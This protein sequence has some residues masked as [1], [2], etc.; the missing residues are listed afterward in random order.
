MS[1]NVVP[2]TNIYLK[3]AP[4]TS[5]NSLFQV[6]G[7]P[8]G[9]NL[10]GLAQ[11]AYSTGATPPP[12]SASTAPTVASGL[13]M[14]FFAGKSA[15]IASPTVSV[16]TITTSNFTPV[17]TGG[18]TN[19]IYIALG[20]AAG[21]TQTAN[22]GTWSSGPVLGTITQGNNYY[23]S[24]YLSNATL[25]TTS[26]SVSNTN[27][28]GIPNKPSSP[29]ISLT[30]LSSWALSW[31]APSTGIAPTSYSWVLCNTS[32]G[33]QLTSGSTASTSVS[34]T[35]TLTQAC[36]Y[37]VYVT[38]VRPEWSGAAS[39]SNSGNAVLNPPTAVSGVDVTAI[40]TTAYTPTV[41]G[42]TGGTIYIYFGTSSSG[43]P[44]TAYTNAS[45][46]A[47]ITQGTT[48]YLNARSSNTTTYTV[49][50]TVSTVVGIPNAPAS[51][52]LTLSN[53]GKFKID[54]GT[55]TGVQPSSYNW[56]LSTTNSKAQQVT[57]G[58]GY[59]GTG[60]GDI[61]SYTLTQD[62]AYY[63]IVYTNKSGAPEAA[64]VASSSS[65]LAS[66]AAVSG[67][68]VTAISTTAYTPTVSGGTGGTIYIYFGTSS[69][70]TP[71]TAYTNA[72]T[73]ASITQ[74]T[75]YYLNAR[76]SNTTTQ[77]ISPTVT[78]VVGIPN[79]PASATL[80]LTTLSNWSIS[81]GTVTG[82]APASYTWY[83]STTNSKTNKVYSNTV[84]STTGT[85]TL[86]SALT[87]DQPYYAIV[88]TNKSGASEA[89]SVT[90]SSNLLASPTAPTTYSLSNL[91]TSNATVKIAGNTETCYLAI[92]TT[93]GASNVPIGL[94]SG[95]TCNAAYLQVSDATVVYGAFTVG[96]NYYVSYFSS[97]TTTGTVSGTVTSS[98][99]VIP[100]A[101]T[102]TTNSN[103]ISNTT[104]NVAATSSTSGATITYS[105]S[106]TSGVSGTGP[107]T[108]LTSD[109]SYT[110][111]ATASTG[112]SSTSATLDA[113]YCLKKPTWVG[114]SPTLSNVTLSWSNISSNAT[115]VFITGQDGSTSYVG[116]DAPA[117]GSNTFT[118]GSYT[119]STTYTSNTLVRYI[120]TAEG[121]RTSYASDR[122]SFIVVKPGIKRTIATP[123]NSLNYI[124]IGGSGGLGCDTS[125]NLGSGGGEAGALF[126]TTTTLPTNSTL[127][128]SC[129]QNGD[130]GNTS[131]GSG[132][133]SNVLSGDGFMGCRGGAGR[134]SGGSAYGGAG[135]CAGGGGSGSQIACWDVSL[136]IIAG[137]G[138]GMGGSGGYQ[139]GKGG[140]GGSSIRAGTSNKHA[141]GDPG[142]SF[143][144]N[145]Y[146]GG[147]GG[148]YYGGRGAAEGIGGAS[149]GIYNS[150]ATS[151]GTSGTNMSIADSNAN[152]GA[153]GDGANYYGTSTGGGG[154]GYGGGGAGVARNNN[155]S[156]N[157]SG[158]GGGATFI[159]DG[160]ATAVG[161]ASSPNPLVGIYCQNY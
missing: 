4:G 149:G 26:L 10:A 67:V 56:Y 2:A 63:A 91:T 46:A 8:G 81:W 20:T 140:K 111:T 1:S 77:T 116:T 21:G 9:N 49:T 73:A 145:L 136:R 47:S 114:W 18:G 82:V 132:Y 12:F 153:G 79:A 113:T 24:T 94:T 52:T 19:T 36:N 31:T 142:E 64:S 97:N 32:A 23:I 6:F 40:S 71:A 89:A 119:T 55:V 151:A 44:A 117:T 72:S 54:W 41:S 65:T 11:I 39:Q 50:A 58:T 135:G 70:G 104:F 7:T 121:T 53:L 61:T 59:T 75:T 28:F 29:S 137:G 112:Y 158:G 60:T 160:S 161:Y 124:C 122:A 128:L 148:G 96:S 100:V 68:D 13:S 126:G 139:G 123:T 34:G 106:P 17:V 129:G 134:G 138:G 16:S 93:S 5:N 42:G 88:Y 86:T 150:T 80:T 110:V 62:Q 125:N 30:N 33:T 84:T 108:G 103:Y 76:S 131:I 48:Y 144:N 87:Q 109:T 120:V 141:W 15:Y 107:F 3:T 152:V 95:G 43:T 35:T 74:G 105:I 90:S 102:F 101:P 78:T 130:N 25:T 37:A 85:G 51:A 83:L 92:G 159:S 147:N 38:A 157:S 127:T 133:T 45:T 154:G 14:S 118:S 27:A 66:P 69:S 156:Y 99:L 143:L 155:G 57:S 22:W 115:R 146:D 98:A